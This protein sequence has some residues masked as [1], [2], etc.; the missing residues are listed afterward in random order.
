MVPPYSNR[1]SRVPP[2]SSELFNTGFRLRDYHPVSC[3]FP[4]TWAIAI[5]KYIHWAV[6]L[7]LAATHRISVDFFSSRYLDVSVPWVSP[8]HPYVFRMGYT[9]NSVG[10]PIQTLSDQCLL[11]TPRHFSQ[12]AT[13]FFASDCL[14]IH[15][16]L[17]YT[18]LYILKSFYYISLRILCNS[19]ILM[20]EY[21][22]APT[23]SFLIR[24]TT[25]SLWLGA[26]KY[27]D[28]LK[29]YSFIPVSS[30]MTN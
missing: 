3:W 14:G 21:Y 6:P 15:R 25:V 18:W 27:Q 24:R 23:L 11:P 1:I 8:P 16:M 22:L 2:Y 9:I 13:S 12:A 5:L 10:S 19:P 4:T 30:L 7:S 28:R 20:G 17:F 26:I 29:L